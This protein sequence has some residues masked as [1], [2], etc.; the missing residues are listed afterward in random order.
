MRQRCL[1]ISHTVSSLGQLAAAMLVAAAL[2]GCPENTT[3]PVVPPN[4][5]GTN[6]M[7]APHPGS[8]APQHGVADQ[9]PPGA[10]GMNAA[11]LAHYQQG[12]SKWAAGDLKGAEESFKQATTADDNAFQAFY[13]LGAVQERLDSPAAGNS[14]KKAFTIEPRYDRAVVAYGLLQAKKGNLSEADTF[15]T[16]Q[17]SKMPKSAPI[18]AALAEVKSLQR[19]TTGA[20]DLASEAL[21]LNP[22]YSPA[23]MTIARDH[24]RNRRLDLALFA[25]QAVLD[26]IGA[27][28]PARDKDNAEGYLL[29]AIIL[30]EQDKRVGAMENFRKALN[31]R[32]DLTNARIKLATYLLESGAATEALPMLQQALKYDRR[33]VPAHLALGDAYRLTGEFTKAK[34]EFEWV[35]RQD[36]SLSEVH[37]NLGL[38]YMFAPKGAIPGLNEKQQ[39]EA[40]IASFDKFKELRSKSDQ[41]DVEELLKQANLKKAEIEALEKA[42]QPIQPVP[43]PEP[44]TDPAAQ[45]APAPGG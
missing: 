23:M 44:E 36:A 31:L 40:A 6:P 41:A 29:R 5:N 21:K 43:A 45:P 15:L 7:V 3:G 20:Q 18:T 22:G 9:L 12:M 38:L 8:G 34:A 37:Y 1:F 11:A 14:Y 35:S 25:L 27:D 10:T 39:V 32:P 13:S 17:R 19:D 42:N 24:Y 16:Q 28:N 30:S 4:P 26:G 33:N 2:T